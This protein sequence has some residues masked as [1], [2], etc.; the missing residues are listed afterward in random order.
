MITVKYT[1]RIKLE[2]KPPVFNEELGQGVLQTIE[3]N[4]PTMTEE[5]FNSPIGQMAIWDFKSTLVEEWIEV[6][7]ERL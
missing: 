4:F 3:V 1:V 5:E 7:P 2:Q 6:I